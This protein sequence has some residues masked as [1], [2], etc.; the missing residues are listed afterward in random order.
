[1]I[2]FRST[3]QL[4]LILYLLLV[5]VGL[6]VRIEPAYGD[7]EPV[8]YQEGKDVVWVPTA[9]ALADK[10]LDLAKVTSQDY[11]ID[12]GSGDGRIVITAAKRGARALGIE[13]NPD[14]VALSK[15]NAVKEGVTAKTQFLQ[16]DLFE[17]DFSQ[18]TVITMFLLPEINLKLRPKILDL[19]PGTRIASNSFNM[20]EWEPDQTVVVTPEEGCDNKFC[21]AYFWVVPAKVAG[22]W[23]LPQGE[24]WLTQSFQ[25][26]SGTLKT[27]S[28]VVAITKGRM[29]GDLISFTA[30]G[31]QYAGRLSG[32][33][34]QGTCRSGG[35]TVKWNASRD[36]GK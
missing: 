27:G 8:P 3:R 29:N 12:L 30:G 36:S 20:D 24:L 25:M 6:F 26:I 34:M 4:L 5:A 18:A 2:R 10:M 1:M 32:N 33:T 9:Q 19:K 7:Y 23:K 13:Y 17:S 22:A 35:S 16:A 21:E 28:N 31:A 15:R 11:V 14:L